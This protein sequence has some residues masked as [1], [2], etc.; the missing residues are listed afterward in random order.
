MRLHD[1]LEF[2]ARENPDH[3]FADMNGASISYAQ[4]NE[5]A[6]RMAHGYLA[7]GLEKGDRISYLSKNSI[8]MAIMFFAASKAGERAKGAVFASDAFLPFND[9]L[10]VALDAGA[11]AAIQ[12]GGSKN[13]EK[14]I[15]FADERGIA[16][17][18]TGTRHFLH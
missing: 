14:C 15:Q 2:F 16:M 11:T 7:S 5:R 9:A 3:P 12:P 18:F 4:A 13:D 1:Y 8:D 17:V 6:N 10:E